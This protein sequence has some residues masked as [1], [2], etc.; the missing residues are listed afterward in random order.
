MK[1]ILPFL[2]LSAFLIP[3]S[4]T[5]HAQNQN[6]KVFQ[7]ITG[8]DKGNNNNNSTNQSANQSIAN[9]QNKTGQTEQDKAVKNV[10][11]ATSQVAKQTGEALSNIGNQVGKAFQNL[12]GI[13]NGGNV[14]KNNQFH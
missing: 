9:D 13:D 3:F 6:N 11:Q 10:T 7:N 1:Y 12:T 14:S 8:L 4:Y 5:V 2:L